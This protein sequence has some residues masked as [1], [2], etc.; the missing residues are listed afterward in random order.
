[1]V[2]SPK[3]YLERA[4][5]IIAENRYMVLATTDLDCKPWSNPV[6]Y[7]YDNKYAFYFLSNLDSRHARNIIVNPQVGIAIFDS[8]QKLGLW[9]EVQMEAK[10]FPISVRETDKIEEIY[11]K[12][13]FQMPRVSA[14]ELFEPDAK[15]VEK[16]D[17]RFFKVTPIK[18][19]INSLGKHVRVELE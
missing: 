9:S 17:S 14:E 2:D 16:I 7:A 8:S 12:R 18:S 19:Y 4:R 15:R 13:F 6:F 10:A 1:M 3:A 5:K 11:N